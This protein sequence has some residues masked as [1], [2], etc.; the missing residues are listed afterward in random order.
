ML[1]SMLIVETNI[2]VE[3]NFSI[4]SNPAKTIPGTPI[5]WKMFFCFFFSNTELINTKS[6]LSSINLVILYFI[7]FYKLT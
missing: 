5:I 4:Q 7:S 2:A 3:V 1:S 6:T